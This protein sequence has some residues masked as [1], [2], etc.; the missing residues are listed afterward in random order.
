M[1]RID[2]R[3][4]STSMDN[5]ACNFEALFAACY[6][7]LARLLYRATGDK[8]RAEEFAAEAFW[9]LYNKPPSD[10]TNIEGW[11]YRTGVRLAIDHLKKDRRRARYEALSQLFRGTP[12]PHQVVEQQEKL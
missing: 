3:L 6:R 7:R 5:V 4:L 8:G 1:E 2:Q 12:N 9:R 11:L 10:G